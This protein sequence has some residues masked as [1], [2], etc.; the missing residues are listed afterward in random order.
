MNF[1][2]R[3]GTKL[4]LIK[5]HVYEC[6]KGHPL[7]A[8]CSPS[9][10]VFLINEH[11]EV[12]LSVRGIEPHKGMLDAFGGFVNGEETAEVAVGR[13][14]ME[15]LSLRVDEYTAPEFLCTSVGHVLY[16]GEALPLLSIFFWSRL[17]TSRKLS[18]LDDVADIHITSLDDLDMNLLHDNDVRAGIE[19][20]KTVLS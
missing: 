17:K 16:K 18:P 2:R 10:G 11:N 1:C 6:E 9:A 19:K 13:E 3:C 8:N 5:G 20:L 4:R 12:L 15:E 7:Y 14:L